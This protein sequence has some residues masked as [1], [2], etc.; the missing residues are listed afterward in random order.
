M[1][2][3]IS[4]SLSCGNVATLQQYLRHDKHSIAHNEK[5]Y[6]LLLPSNIPNILVVVLLGGILVR[7]S[8]N[9]AFTAGKLNESKSYADITHC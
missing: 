7:P 3:K 6:V 9:A 4:I 2:I 5:Y 8:V 1:K